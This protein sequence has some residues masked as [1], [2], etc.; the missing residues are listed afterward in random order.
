MMSASSAI[1]PDR[2][3]ESWAQLTAVPLGHDL[4]VEDGHMRDDGVLAEPMLLH[5][6]PSNDFTGGLR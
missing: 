2:K 4:R 1:K 5:V 3:H 6:D